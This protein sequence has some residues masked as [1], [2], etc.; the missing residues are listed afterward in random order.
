M[1]Y[2]LFIYG[3]KAVYSKPTSDFRFVGYLFID[4]VLDYKIYIA[5]TLSTVVYNTAER[6]RAHPNA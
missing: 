6:S 4:Y 5:N 2:T 1:P 3:L